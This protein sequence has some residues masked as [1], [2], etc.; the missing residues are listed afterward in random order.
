MNINRNMNNRNMNHRNMNNQNIKNQ[1]RNGGKRNSGKITSEKYTLEQLERTRYLQKIPEPYMIRDER[2]IIDFK[3]KT[4]SGYAKTDV[5][6]EMF[7]NIKEENIEKSCYWG[8]QLLLS[9]PINSIWDKMITWAAQNININNP[10]LPLF[11]CDRYISQMN[12]FNNKELSGENSLRLRNIQSC[13]NYLTEFICILAISR[14][15][16]IITKPK[17][18]GQDFN[19]GIFKSKLTAQDTLL[20]N[21]I[22]KTGDPSEIGIVVNEF[23][24]YITQANR[25]RDKALYWINWMIEW[26]KLNRKRYGKFECGYRGRKDINNKYHTDIV[27][28]IWEIILTEVVRRIY[29]HPG[30]NNKKLKKQINALWKMYLYNFTLGS[31]SRKFHIIIWAILMLTMPIDWRIPIS[32]RIYVVLQATANINMMIAELK[33]GEIRSNVYKDAKFNI[34]TRNNYMLPNNYQKMENEKKIREMELQKKKLM[35]KNKKGKMSDKSMSK[36]NKVQEID[37]MM[38]RRNDKNTTTNRNNI[39]NKNNKNN[40]NNISPTNLQN[41]VQNSFQNLEQYQRMNYQTNQQLPLRGFKQ[42]IDKTNRA[43]EQIE[44]IINIKGTG[45]PN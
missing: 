41:R 37:L 2:K 5:I 33:K 26:D 1:R 39:N 13:R 17:I 40:I 25:N 16:K 9:G 32:D 8:L 6:S 19:V 21:N 38:F 4:F 31:K 3:K 45:W 15:N 28:L 11:I 12:L 20:V 14:K 42:K 22:L 29:N 35:K 24:N 36:F 44:K 27:W 18:K 34:L 30:N 43:I 23:A 10:K 7:K